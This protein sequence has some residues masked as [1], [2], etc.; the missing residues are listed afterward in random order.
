MRNLHARVHRVRRVDLLVLAG[1]VHFFGV[2]N[3]NGMLTVR[4]SLATLRAKWKT[5]AP[6]TP[7]YFNDKLVEG[8]E[9]AEEGE[10]LAD[11]CVH[12]VMNQK[13]VG[14]VVNDA[15]LQTIQTRT[16]ATTNTRPKTRPAL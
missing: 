9:G 8:A 14:R 11:F 13:R 7:M 10:S 16:T 1:G 4:K 12:F 2:G 5:H 6:E 15:P 3:D